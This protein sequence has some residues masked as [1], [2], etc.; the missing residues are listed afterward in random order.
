MKYEDAI[1]NMNV[2]PYVIILI[3]YYIIYTSKS[4]S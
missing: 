3:L 2:N 1:Q 4:Y